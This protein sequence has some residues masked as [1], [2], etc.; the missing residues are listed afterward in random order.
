MT[1]SSILDIE[2]YK[3][4][5]DL[6]KSSKP[7]PELAVKTPSKLNFSFKKLHLIQN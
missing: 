4:E 5:I 6:Y 7:Y 3:Y 2:G 1:D